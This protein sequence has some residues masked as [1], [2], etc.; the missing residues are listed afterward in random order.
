MRRLHL[1][2][3]LGFMATCGLA[4]AQ[5]PGVLYTWAGT[6]N[7]HDWMS[8][9]SNQV[10]QTTVTN[11]VGGELTVTEMGD[12]F[13]D[14]GGT[15]VIS[16]G[17]N[18]RLESSTA[19]GG[20]DVT[21]L[22]FLEIDVAH[23]GAGN[24]NVQFYVQAT[25]AF[26]YLGAG[27][28]GPSGMLGG[29]DYSIGPG[30]HTLQFP[31]S[32]LTPTQQTYIRGIGLNVRDHFD[33]GNLTWTVSEMRSVG[34]PLTTRTLV[35]HDTGSSDGGRQGA[36]ANFEIG[37]I[38]GNDG[39]QNQTGLSHNP[40]GSGSLRWTDRGGTGEEGSP[41][42]AAI[43]WGN[44]TSNANGTFGQRLTDVS[45]YTHVTYRVSATDP[46]GAGGELGMQA[47]FQTGSFDFQEA[48]VAALLIDGAFHDLT[49]PLAAI[50][51]RQNVQFSGLNLFAH[52]NDLVIDVDNIRYDTIAGQQGDYNENG[53]V[54][55]ADYTVWRDN[56]NS[57]IALPNEGASA[58]TV[59]QADYDF[60]K[61]HFGEGAMGGGALSSAVPEP[62]ALLL[63]TCGAVSCLFVRRKSRC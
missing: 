5:T 8:A 49:F 34:T 17:F 55:A 51:D 25:P 48:G 39:G 7:I 21:G 20:L 2:S 33:Q 57:A 15:I 12:G 28:N 29:A 30:A 6:G 24:V 44:G 18:R 61:L 40:A 53:I 27:S 59:D 42:G 14:P 3:L 43:G 52:A 50:T 26:T 19:T 41:S 23:N 45:N 9:G 36:F 32:A 13:G 31:I 10:N 60:W 63:G 38:V 47:Y 1:I 56:L 62:A 16:D 4:N 58:N 35:T 54:D 46:L 11:L 37:A 22:S